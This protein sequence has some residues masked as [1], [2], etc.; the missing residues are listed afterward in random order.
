MRN[1]A[2]GQLV[3]EAQVNVETVR[4]YERRGLM[5][6]RAKDRRASQVS[7]SVISSAQA[8]IRETHSLWGLIFPARNILPVRLKEDTFVLP[9]GGGRDIIA[10]FL[11]PIEDF[12]ASLRIR[13]FPLSVKV[14]H[15]FI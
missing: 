1:S 13:L 15:D 11:Q 4:Y 14:C 6:E 12:F 10:D 8:Q 5:P 2:I 9:L 3:K 7:K